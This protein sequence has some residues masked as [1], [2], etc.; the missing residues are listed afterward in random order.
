MRSTRSPGPDSGAPTAGLLGELGVNTPAI[1]RRDGIRPR[2]VE[3]G[4]GVA[5]AA[6]WG[7]GHELESFGDVSLLCVFLAMAAAGA[8]RLAMAVMAT[9]A[10][11]SVGGVEIAVEP[12]VVALGQEVRCRVSYDRGASRS[13]IALSARFRGREWVAEG[14]S[15]QTTYEHELLALQVPL[16][17]RTSADQGPAAWEGSFVVPADAPPSFFASSGHVEYELEVRFEARG[18][19]DWSR[20][21]PIR[22]YPAGTE[23]PTRP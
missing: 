4:V 1:R 15:S 6:W 9:L 16:E 17:E 19:P 23:P 14:G 21:V 7:I 5:L 22:V 11:R 10:E 8:V 2:L 13:G 18:W 3:L 12:N 20:G